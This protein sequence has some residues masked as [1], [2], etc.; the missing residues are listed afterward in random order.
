MFKR[1]SLALAA[2][3]L[4]TTLTATAQDWGGSWGGGNTGS[5]SD[6][7]NDSCMSGDGS[8]RSR[9]LQVVGLTS[10]NRLVCFNEFSPSNARNIGIV[11]GFTAGTFGADTKLIG[12]DFRV[13]DRKLYGVGDKGGIYTINVSNGALTRV[14]QLTVALEGVSFGVDFN[15]P[16]DRLRVTSNTGQN[17]RH[18]VNA[19]GATLVDGTLDYPPGALA[20]PGPAAMGI[21]GSAYT[22]NDLDGSTATTLYALD[23]KLDQIAIQS[24]P[25]DGSLAA[26]GKLTVNA[27]EN[28]DA[29]FDIYSVVRNGIAVEVRAFAAFSSV[30][31]ET[32]SSFYGINLPQGKATSRGA[33]S[34]QNKVI[35]IAIPL[36]QL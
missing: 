26:T 31:S 18:N 30:G 8:T 14:S 24:P 4:A 2:T 3:L 23:S 12:I 19:G 20:T 9:T 25:N 34:S 29:G 16:A 6:G 17:L 32:S 5:F 36:N 35:D 21:V 10:D 11:T 1:S 28:G 15:P 22:N 7:G 27:V 33:F 13:Q